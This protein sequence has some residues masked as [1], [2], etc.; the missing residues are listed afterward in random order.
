M[1]RTAGRRAGGGAGEALSSRW[2]GAGVAGGRGHGGLYVDARCASSRAGDAAGAPTGVSAG[3]Q[4]G[5][6]AVAMGTTL[7]GMRV[8]EAALRDRAGRTMKVCGLPWMDTIPSPA[9]TSEGSGAA[10][11]ELVVRMCRQPCA[12]RCR[13]VRI[14]TCTSPKVEK[15]NRGVLVA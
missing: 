13:V 8:Q 9:P 15:R 7:E 3:R 12:Y 4:G 14:E 10:S 1:L 6:G 2:M 11:C 5:A